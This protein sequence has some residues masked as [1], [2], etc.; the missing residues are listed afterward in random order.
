MNAHWQLLVLVVVDSSLEVKWCGFELFI[1]GGGLTR[2]PEWI[3]LEFGGVFTAV[4]WNGSW[5]KMAVA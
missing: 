5:Q 2:L 1:G 3:T 4:L